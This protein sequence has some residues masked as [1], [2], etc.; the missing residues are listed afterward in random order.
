[1]CG[2]GGNFFPQTN[3]FLAIVM[4]GVKS[5]L[6]N[7]TFQIVNTITGVHLPINLSLPE[8]QMALFFLVLSVLVTLASTPN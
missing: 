1:M 8:Q 2:I 5:K 7:T 6:H 4:R 3:V